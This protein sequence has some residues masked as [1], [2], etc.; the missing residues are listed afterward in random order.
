MARIG[1][2][3]ASPHA[4]ADRERGPLQLVSNPPDFFSIKK[5]GSWL[6]LIHDHTAQ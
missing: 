2:G 4:L 3:R 6:D 1:F 5:A